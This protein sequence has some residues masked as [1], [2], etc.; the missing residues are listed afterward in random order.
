MFQRWQRWPLQW[1]GIKFPQER[2][3]WAE[4]DGGQAALGG[5]EGRG[6]PGRLRT[7]GATASGDQPADP[8]G[9]VPANAG[10]VR[11]PLCCHVPGASGG[12]SRKP[13]AVVR[14]AGEEGHQSGRRAR[15]GRPEPGQRSSGLFSHLFPTARG[16]SEGFPC[17]EQTLGRLSGERNVRG[18]RR[19][20][21]K[22][23]SPP[24]STRHTR[25]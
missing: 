17:N 18:G 2:L 12:G 7:C 20:P 15:E 3:A 14:E 9:A 24:E 5:P 21:Y 19:C 11:K 16:T 23:T 6:D 25:V 1:R 8:R 10:A 4:Q 13:W 22:E